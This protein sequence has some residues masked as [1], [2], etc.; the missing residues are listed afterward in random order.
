MS[1]KFYNSPWF[2]LDF[3]FKCK[4]IEVIVNF[5]EIVFYIGIDVLRG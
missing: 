3:S 4:G 5:L 2:S 1:I